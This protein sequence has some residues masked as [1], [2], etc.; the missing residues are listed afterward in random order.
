MRR[1]TDYTMQ[2]MTEQSSRSG[3]GNLQPISS[4]VHDSSAAIPDGPP[5][6]RTRRHEHAKHYDLAGELQLAIC[7]R[8]TQQAARPSKQVSADKVV[9][10][11]ASL[12]PL[13]MPITRAQRKVAGSL[14][15]VSGQLLSGS[16]SGQQSRQSCTSGKDNSAAGAELEQPLEHLKSLKEPIAKRS[17]AGNQ[18]SAT[19]QQLFDRPSCPHQ[20]QPELQGSKFAALDPAAQQRMLTKQALQALRDVTRHISVVEE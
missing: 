17:K 12:A 18:P 13:Q 20:A 2:P 11:A 10:S 5:M 6:K 9:R 3:H 4:C 16:C 19:A 7:R 14:L 1:K 8:T 15:A